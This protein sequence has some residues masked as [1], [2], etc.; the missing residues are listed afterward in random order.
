VSSS[1]PTITGTAAVAQTLMATPGTWTGGGQISYTYRWQRCG[2]SYPSVVAADSPT[3]YVRLDDAT[4][5]A[6]AN[7]TTLGSG[8]YLG[9][10]TLG[11]SG[12]FAGDPDTSVSLDGVD[13]A[14]SMPSPGTTGAFSLEFWAN[15]SGDGSSGAVGY[16]TLAGSDFEH[17]ILW[18]TN[19]GGN[20]GRL[21]AWFNDHD[22]FYST[23][24]A[25]LNAW[26]HIVYTFDGAAE[27]FYIDGDPAG[28]HATT[29]PS[30]NSI[31]YL[32]AYDRT[33]YM[34]RGSIDDAAVYAQA[35]TPAQV[36]RHYQAGLEAGCADIVGATTAS[37]LVVPADVN[38]DLRAIVTATNSAGSGDASSNFTSSIA[39]AALP[40]NPVT[41]ENALPG[42]MDWQSPEATA[43]AIEGYTS[44]V[45]A[46][47][48]DTVGLHVSTNPAASYRVEVYRLG[49]YA[50]AGARLMT[51]VPSC[52]TD[53]AGSARSAPAPDPVTGEVDAG[54]PVTDSFPVPSSWTSGYYVARLR[55]TSGPQAGSAS[56]VYFIVRAAPGRNAAILVEAPVNT[57]E[58]YNGWGGE[59]LYSGLNGGP[60]A[61]KVSF[62]RPGYG[63]SPLVWEYPTLRFLERE[64]YDVS[65]TTNYDLAVDPAE[66]LH[67]KL[68]IS[69]GHD[70]YWTKAMRD[71]LTAARDAGVNL[72]FLGGNDMYWQARYEDNGRTLVEYRSLAGD[73]DPDPATKTVR[74]TQ[75]SPPNPQCTLVGLDD[76][77]GIRVA[78]EPPRDYSIVTSALGDPWMANTEFEAGATLPDLVG[79]E[80]DAIEPGCAT[81]P[82]TR[83]FHY[84]GSP[85]NA[86]STRYTA[87]SGASVYA[88]GTVQFAWGLD[89]WG[90]HDAP[91]D[92]RI[93]QFIR[94]ALAAMTH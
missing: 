37:H 72:A 2:A 27:H 10:P 66:L 82:L 42:T 50:G 57:W 78:G 91:P 85:A 24:T 49:W 45:S 39:A 65:Y 62:N 12:A 54:W 48:G 52:S 59:S 31:Y 56:S 68:I 41:A 75:L 88:T 87:P 11:Q 6:A 20:G 9:G 92:P 58:A 81:P 74:W 63:Q 38:A 25:S 40:S 51:C 4:G 55:L 14:V 22:L 61:V 94:N 8:T 93:Q 46:A 47:P 26:H 19:G 77:G 71:N 3:S 7:S 44:Q 60:P 35:L 90:G 17:R 16:G 30:W 80:W 5:T 18:Q 34:F 79:Y 84:T 15:L 69:V 53:E 29:D 28:T 76:L 86:D 1:A 33:N 64:G 70:E 23:S 36:E 32:G 67:H 73:P 43:S 21:L 89:G 83:F 13:D